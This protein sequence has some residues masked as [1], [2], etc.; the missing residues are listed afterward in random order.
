MPKTD[1]APAWFSAQME[2]NRK[3]I[4]EDTA[5]TVGRL[6]AT[7]NEKIEQTNRELS[8]H[9]HDVDAINVDTRL[10]TC[11][12]SPTMVLNKLINM[13]DPNDRILCI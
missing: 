7:L 5:A 3:K 10:C 8:K 1:E 4:A 6:S 11:M 13:I 12:A 9:N 2:A